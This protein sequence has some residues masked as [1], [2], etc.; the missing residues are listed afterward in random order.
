MLCQAGLDF[1]LASAPELPAA[2]KCIPNNR[3]EQAE[4]RQLSLGALEP[5]GLDLNPGSVTSSSSITLSK[6]FTF[7]NSVSSFVNGDKNHA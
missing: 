6:F 4:H 2:G 5:H 3:Q 7:S 1:G